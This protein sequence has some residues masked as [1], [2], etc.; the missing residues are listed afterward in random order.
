MRSKGLASEQMTIISEQRSEAQK[1]VMR[2]EYGMKEGINP[3][4][5][6]SV[7]LFRYLLSV[8]F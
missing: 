1:V 8:I 5:R 7:D 3:L 4:F 2:R 6:L